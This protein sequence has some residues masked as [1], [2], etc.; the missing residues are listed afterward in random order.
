M[1][2]V[3]TVFR[4]CRWPCVKDWVGS[5]PVQSECEIHIGTGDDKRRDVYA[6]GFSTEHLKRWPT[7]PIALSGKQ[8]QPNDGLEYAL[9]LSLYL[10]LIPIEIRLC[11]K[12]RP[13]Q[14]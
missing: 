3:A 14:D 9:C 1:D 11:C 4:P 2:A 5:I 8:V 7:I 13:L 12:L 6:R 10:L